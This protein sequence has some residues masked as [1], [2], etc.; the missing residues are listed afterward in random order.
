MNRRGAITLPRLNPR[1]IGAGA[2]LI[3]STVLVALAPLD[4]RV[5]A[6]VLAGLLGAIGVGAILR[7]P[8]LGVLAWS[9][10]IGTVT[11]P[12]WVSPLP[13]STDV[14]VKIRSKS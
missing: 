12:V 6:L 13:V 8:Y 3:L 5:S 4:W 10:T 2:L 14:A 1:T 11:D 7:R 9:M